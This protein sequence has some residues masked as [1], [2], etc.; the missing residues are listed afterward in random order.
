MPLLLL[1]R[2][3]SGVLPALLVASREDRPATPPFRL[4]VVLG[5]D[6]ALAEE[7]D[8]RSVAE[9]LEVGRALAPNV[10]VHE[11]HVLV[12]EAGHRARHADAADVRAAADAVDPAADRD[13][14]LDHRALAAELDQAAVIGAVLG[15]ELALLDE[16][17]AVATLAHGPAEQPFGPQLLV[18]LG[19]RRQ[20]RQVEDEVHQHLGHV[21]GLSRAAGNA[22]HGQVGLR[23]PLPA[24]VVRHSHRPGGV[25]LHRRDAAVGGA[26]A[27]RDHRRRLGGEPIDPLVDGDRLAVGADPEAGPVALAID[28]LVAERSLDHEHE[29]V[30]LSLLGVEP[31]LHVLL[32]GLEGDHLVVDHDPRH[33]RDHALN[34]VLEARVGGGRHGDRIPLARQPDRDPQDMSRHRLGRRLVGNELGCGCHRCPL[35]FSV[36]SADP[37]QGVPHQ[38]VHNPAPA[39]G[40]RHHHHPGRLRADLADLLRPLATGDAT[41]RRER[42][43]GVLGRDERDQPAFVGDVHRIDPEQLG[44][45]GDDRRDRHARLVDQDRDARCPGKL[46]E[47]RGDAAPGRVAQA[48]HVRPAA[49]QQRVDRRPEALGVGLELGVELELV[50]GQHDR[51]AVLADRARHQHPVS[52]FEPCRTE[53]RPL[54]DD[55]DPGR[56]QVHLIRGAP[57]D[58]LRVAADDL[59]AGCRRG[60]RDRLDLGPQ[61]RRVQ[62]LLEDH[63]HGQRARPGTGHREVVDGAVDR[64][65]ADRAAGE[66]QRFDDEAVGGHRQSPGAGQRHATRVTELGQGLAGRC[67]RRDQQPL[68]QRL[69]RLATGTM[70]QGDPLV[71]EARPLG[72][73]G[74]DDLQDPLLAVGDGRRRSSGAHTASRVRA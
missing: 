12:G 71:T 17:G 36:R 49:G 2:S 45:G 13:I 1:V 42:R 40:G 55:S 33:S 7:V 5:L 29:R 47:H 18:E 68:D 61:H 43:V 32:A 39:E 64:E 27:D 31:R 15:G 67:E 25:V 54:V 26:G 62:A 41:Q 9:A 52:G 10:R 11:R 28:L 72:A 21:V 38:L 8:H 59:D 23:A 37:W 73:R 60:R 19:H 6:V 44:G 56:G 35:S 46:V 65:L 20:A 74:L 14:A 50:A 3:R 30:E 48:V 24:E 22:D 70:R 53:L 51:G 4:D 58:H 69:R 16:P 63:R 34:D 66:A 57:L